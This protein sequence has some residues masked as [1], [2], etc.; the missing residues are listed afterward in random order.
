MTHLCPDARAWTIA[1]I[2]YDS[3]A[4]RELT[5]DLHREQVATYGTADD[6]DTTPAEEFEPPIGVFLV[7]ER[8]EEALSPAADGA[9]SAPRPQ[10]SNACTCLPPLA[11]EAWG[12]SSS[13]R[14][15][16]TRGAAA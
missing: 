11:A 16:W 9:P 13:T 7:A 8:S 3:P 12:G 10:R 5:Q 14:W 6:P 2:S 1:V 4:A 15:N